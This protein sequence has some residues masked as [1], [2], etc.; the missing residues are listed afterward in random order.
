[1]E[2]MIKNINALLEVAD[3]VSTID[4]KQTR[5]NCR[6]AL[7]SYRRVKGIAD[8]DFSLS[9]S[10]MDNTPVQSSRTT[11]PTEKFGEIKE[12]S[13]IFLVNVE[14]AVNHLDFNKS[15]STQGERLKD[16]IDIA[17]YKDLLRLR[18][19]SEP[20]PSSKKIRQFLYSHYPERSYSD[21]NAIEASV[22]Y[23]DL[24]RALDMFAMAYKDGQAIQIKG[25]N[26]KFW[27]RIL[28]EFQYD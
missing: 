10:R 23:R 2:D 28:K 17:Y 3:K 24:N 26:E 20:K 16:D 14:D 15:I 12:L 7:G 27:E 25:T 1:M 6:L 13:A 8:K 18:F 22:Y 19:F 9:A 4:I 5:A 11:T 21:D